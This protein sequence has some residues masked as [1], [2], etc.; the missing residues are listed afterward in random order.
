VDQ[1]YLH[2]LTPRDET[3]VLEEVLLLEGVLE[4]RW[5]VEGCLAFSG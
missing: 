1:A 2:N 5:R 4:V 3:V